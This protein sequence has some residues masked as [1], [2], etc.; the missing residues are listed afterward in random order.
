MD[1]GKLPGCIQPSMDLQMINKN[2]EVALFYLKKY[3]E[4]DIESITE[5]FVEDIVLRDWKIRV[6]GKEEALRETRKN[7][8]SVDT[9]EIE[10]LSTY[11]NDNT[12]AAELKITIDNLEELYV[13]DVIT[14]NSKKRITSIRAYLGRGD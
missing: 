10:V 5:L 14:L 6:N 1:N 7:F 9:I 12:V 13:V 11:E 8:E 4:K 2:K 3:A